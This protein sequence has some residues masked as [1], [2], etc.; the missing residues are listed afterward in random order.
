MSFFLAT[1]VTAAS[2]SS[3]LGRRAL[4]QAP[5]WS[6]GNRPAWFNNDKVQSG[7]GQTLGTPGV[8]PAS[9]WGNPS[10]HQW[11]QSPAQEAGPGLDKLPPTAANQ[12]SSEAGGQGFS[13]PRPQQNPRN[14]K[15]DI[16]TLSALTAPTQRLRN[17]P[18][19]TIAAP[20]SGPGLGLYQGLRRGGNAKANAQSLA[21]TFNSNSEAAATAV[22][23]AATEGGSSSAVAE[24]VALTTVSHPNIAPGKVNQ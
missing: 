20:T 9:N 8:N 22:A 6:G 10:R 2:T 19:Q 3:G 24:A 23:S 12:G 15:G 16:S 1:G 18:R 5:D 21:E 14:R 11:P 17:V 4:L 13:Q 7:A